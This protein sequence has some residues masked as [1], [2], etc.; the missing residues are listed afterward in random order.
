MATTKKIVAMKSFK[1]KMTE[2]NNKVKIT[3]EKIT[4]LKN[5]L[6]KIWNSL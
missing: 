5:S 3:V 2:I 4:K 1:K 6:N